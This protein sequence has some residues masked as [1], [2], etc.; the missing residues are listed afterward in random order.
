MLAQLRLRDGQTAT[1]LF[2]TPE[3]AS[4]P[5]PPYVALH[6][7]EGTLYVG[8]APDSFWP[9]ASLQHFDPGRGTW[10]EIEIP[11]DV[12]DGL[13]RVED[14]A[15]RQ[16]NQF[17]QEFV[18]DVHGEGDVGYPTFRDGSAAVEV[19][20]IARSAQGWTPLP[21]HSGDQPRQT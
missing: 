9:D 18:A 10:S 21:D 16:W 5:H 13:P 11:Q 8:G 1:A 12:I 4:S 2:A 19:M 17:F 6:G 7:T 20:D 15:Q 3:G 14:G